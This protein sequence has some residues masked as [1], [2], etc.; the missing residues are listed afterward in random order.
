MLD[1]LL[2]AVT[3]GVV[4]VYARGLAQTPTS[5]PE[6]QRSRVLAFA[7]GFAV[8]VG[9]LASP[10]EAAADTS[11]TMHMTQHVLLLSV[12]APLLVAGHPGPAL[13]RG[14]PRAARPQARRAHRVA[15]RTAR[16]H[17]LLTVVVVAT[18]T[19][20]IAV[21]HFPVP[22]DAAVHHA[23]LH[24]IEHMSF[25]V[26][27][28]AL[29]WAV[30]QCVASGRLAVAV[31]SLFASGLVCTALGALLVLSPTPWYPAYVHAGAGA[32]LADQQLAGMVMWGFANLAL[33]VASAVTIGWWLAGLEA[34][35]PARL[36]S[37]AR[38]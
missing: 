16:R 7:A 22:F 34:R 5:A 35:T 26:A 37:G 23:S 9:A 25:L 32:A 2:A 17:G 1:L 31:L 13:T 6:A 15:V 11:L 8:V 29:W 24:A 3:V 27:S 38:P 30:A 12:A 21:W 36:P 4:I 28:L 20:V 19:V 10:F 14:L 18:W 33:V